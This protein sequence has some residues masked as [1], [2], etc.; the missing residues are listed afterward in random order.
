[1][2][3]PS[4]SFKQH[5][6]PLKGPEEL[7]SLIGTKVSADHHKGGA[8]GK[9]NGSLDVFY[10]TAISAGFF[11]MLLESNQVKKEYSGAPVAYVQ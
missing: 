2:V 9:C 7:I 1:M 8:I 6:A 3:S 5:H 10:G 4:Y 11:W